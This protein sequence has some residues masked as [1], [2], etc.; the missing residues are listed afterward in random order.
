M[1][2]ARPLSLEEALSRAVAENP[3]VVE[4]GL[5]RDQ[6]LAR[7]RAAR[8]QFDPALSAS[9]GAD[10]R[11]SQGFI[12][13]FPSSSASD[14][15]NASA[16]V[17]GTTSVG[18]TWAV[19]TRYDRDV[20]T[21]LAALTGPDAQAQEQSTFGAG[22]DV[23]VTQDVLAFLRSSQPRIDVRLA[24][25]RL[26]QAELAVLRSTEGA[27]VQVADAWWAWW[28]AGEAADVAARALEQAAALQAQ[29]EAWFDEGEVARLEVDRVRS[30]RLAAERDRLRS[31]ANVRAAADE[32][33]VLLNL[34]P[35]EA[36]EPV[37]PERAWASPEPT[38]DTAV[39]Q[40][41]AG[42]LEL[43]AARLSVDAARH[44]REDA[45]DRGL[46]TLD[47]TATGG[48]GTLTDSGGGA[49]TGLV[50]DSNNPYATVSLGVTVPLGGRAAMA[51]RSEASTEADIQARRLRSRSL[52]LTASARAAV[53]AVV[54]SRQGL[55]LA[56][57]RLDVARA[58]EDGEQARVDEGVR[59][60]DQL[61]EATRARQ[62]AEADH[63]SAR[64]EL[65]RSELQLA[66]LEGRVVAEVLRVD[67]R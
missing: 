9:V 44:A 66:R 67:R 46:P 57:A 1:A 28:S 47:L 15:W 25:E 59:R 54:T 17:R 62:A 14:G 19:T 49:F 20:T 65:A 21:T 56:E 63:V 8:A 22:I 39:A 37:G 23:S 45:Q 34:E 16:G 3:D 6:A 58:T 18:T 32:V 33:L 52:A 26:D 60:M 4:S 27:L 35:G 53:D 36:I 11:D 29:T 55:A 13:G 48:I 10:S 38:V 24:A 5:L 30:E 64:V 7:T 31:D 12:A 43:T 42:N 50:G 41:L 61:L 40:V 51:A 2:H